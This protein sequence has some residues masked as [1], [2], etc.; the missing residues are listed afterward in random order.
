MM[1]GI[2]LQSIRVGWYVADIHYIS[3]YSEFQ[4]RDLSLIRDSFFPNLENLK[5]FF[6]AC[7]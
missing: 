4:T 7:F 5:A 1:W 3:D 2:G 6:H